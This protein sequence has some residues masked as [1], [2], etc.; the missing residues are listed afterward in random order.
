[1][2]DRADVLVLSHR[3]SR[4]RYFSTG[5]NTTRDSVLVRVQDREG[6][7]GW[8]ETYLIPGVVG[9][10]QALVATLP[11]QDPSLAADRLTH[12]QHANRWALGAVSTAL[13]DLRG[14][15]AGVPSGSLH[16]PRLRDRVTAYASSTGYVDGVPLADVWLA[17][18]DTVRASGYRQLKLRIGRGA[19]SDELP[20][21]EQVVAQALDLTWMADG[22]GAYAFEDALEL[23]IGLEALRMRWLEEPLPTSD[24]AA[25]RPLAD[26]LGIPLAG[27]EILETTAQAAAALS[28]GAFDIVQPD[29]AICGGVGPLLEI[30]TLAAG[31]RI[32]CIPHA[33]NGAILRAATLQVLSVLPVADGLP[34]WATPV[35]EDDVGENPLRT[36]LVRDAPAVE[37]GWVAIPAGPGLGVE[38]DEAVVERYAVAA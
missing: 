3:L 17:E 36:D 21:I 8:G 29:L 20:A 32:A 11:G 16:G 9:E 25:Y 14:R 19:L 35:L 30:A 5:S 7:T 38:V 31:Q 12:L 34:G 1:V 13:D 24:Y 28:A 23:G 6:T 15:I 10:A 33:C 26:A 4:T 18:A 37:D 2:I 27:G 22:N